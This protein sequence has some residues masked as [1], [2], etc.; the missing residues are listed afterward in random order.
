MVYSFCKKFKYLGQYGTLVLQVSEY[1]GQYG[2]LV[3]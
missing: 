3:L 2:I 1:L